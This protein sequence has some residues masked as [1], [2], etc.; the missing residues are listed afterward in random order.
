[1]PDDPDT[2]RQDL[3][4]CERCGEATELVTVIQRLGTTPAYRLFECQACRI[5]T[6]V[7]EQVT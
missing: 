5:I 6:W 1:M 2:E 7:A 4:K 3:P